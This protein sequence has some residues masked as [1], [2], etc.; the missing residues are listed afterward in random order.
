MK[1]G[2]WEEID[3]NLV[4]LKD[5]KN[6]ID[7]AVQAMMMTQS[8]SQGIGGFGK[9]AVSDEAEGKSAHNALRAIAEAQYH[10]VKILILK[11][12]SRN[13]CNKILEDLENL[14]F[15]LKT[16]ENDISGYIQKHIK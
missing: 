10:A 8:T 14:E 4:K 11:R 3:R 16:T 12:L 13:N 7:P 5:A 1:G 6:K 15:Q 2:S 9:N